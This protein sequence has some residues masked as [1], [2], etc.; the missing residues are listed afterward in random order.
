MK[1]FVILASPR[2]GSN[3]LCTL[4]QSHPDVLCHHELFNPEGIFVS[5]LLRNMGFTLGTIEERNAAPLNFLQNIWI[6]KLGHQWLGFKMTHY[7]QSEV[8]NEVCADPSIHKIVLKR[9][10][11]LK[12]YVSRLIAERNNRWEDYRQMALVEQVNP[13]EVDYQQ[14]KASIDFNEHYYA[15]LDQLICG[16][17]TDLYYENLLDQETQRR[18]LKELKLTN[19]PL[20]AQ[21][22]WQN[23]QPADELISNLEC[24]VQQLQAHP[25]DRELLSELTNKQPTV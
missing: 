22:R 12:T 8:L 14:L 9:K 11:R 7:Q 21:S 1:R 13:I 4:L 19:H 25:V 20:K 3:L 18:L 16:S 17:R 6:N 15:K 24:L 5:L 2:T 10:A 23:P